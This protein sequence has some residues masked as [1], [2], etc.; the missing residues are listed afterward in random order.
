MGAVGSHP[1]RDFE[2]VHDVQAG[3]VELDSFVWLAGYR[4]DRVLHLQREAQPGA[5][6][7]AGC[8]AEKL[9]TSSHSIGPLRAA[10]RAFL[11]YSRAMDE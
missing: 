4:T 6:A 5:G 11:F 9:A 8:Q 7:A 2:R 3:D 10:R 1:W